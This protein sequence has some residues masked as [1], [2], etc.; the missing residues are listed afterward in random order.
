MSNVIYFDFKNKENRLLTKGELNSLSNRIDE[1]NVILDLCSD[2][3]RDD[4]ILL[5]LENELDAIINQLE[6]AVS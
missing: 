5:N 6:K 3:G 4:D 2:C 1:I